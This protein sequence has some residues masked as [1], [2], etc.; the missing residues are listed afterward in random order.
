MREI[1]ERIPQPGGDLLLGQ[2]VF[3]IQAGDLGQQFLAILFHFGFF[4]WLADHTP[5]FAILCKVCTFVQIY[6]SFAAGDVQR[7]LHV[8]QDI[9]DR[10][11]PRRK[12]TSPP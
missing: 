5:E 4:H 7:L 2:F 10:F 6:L 3:E 9:L 11:D 8:S 12:A 1:E